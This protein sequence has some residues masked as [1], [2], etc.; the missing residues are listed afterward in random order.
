MVPIPNCVLPVQVEFFSRTANFDLSD[1]LSS[2]L[3]FS[4]NISSV[5][6]SLLL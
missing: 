5:R 2:T 1:Q 3:L 4:A 6:I